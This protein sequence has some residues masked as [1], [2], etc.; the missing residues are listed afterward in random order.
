[1]D[2]S[3]LTAV[4][5]YLDV[6]NNENK[7]PLTVKEKIASKLRMLGKLKPLKLSKP[8]D[9]DIILEAPVAEVSF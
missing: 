2:P 4:T 1:M 7:K 5:N 6:E 8:E 3:E 9:P